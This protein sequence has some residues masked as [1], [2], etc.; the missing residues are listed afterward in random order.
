MQAGVRWIDRIL[1]KRGRVY[2]FS[3][4]PDCIM[5]IQLK[6]A[7]HEV[8]V[9][10]ETIYKGEQVLAIHIWNERM[11]KIPK[12]GVNLEWALVLRQKMIR[13]F[14]ILAKE[15]QNDNRYSHIRALCGESALFTL[16]GHTGGVRMMKHLGFTVFPYYHPLGRFGE[17]WEN[18]FSWWLMWTYNEKSLHSRKFFRLQ[19]T[20]IWITINEFLQRYGEGKQTWRR[21]SA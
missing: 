11:P 1:R 18:L 10:G 12:E 20:E 17:F 8:S 16:T 15:I 9:G 4:D 14:E 3:Y 7:N 2:E 5:R 6:K 21:C 13:S 19:R